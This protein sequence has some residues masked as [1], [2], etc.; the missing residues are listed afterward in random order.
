MYT[1]AVVGQS[2][3]LRPHQVDECLLEAE[4]EAEG[5]IELLEPGSIRFSVDTAEG[6]GSSGSPDGEVGCSRRESVSRA[7]LL[8]Q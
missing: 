5:V 6:S 8:P 3:W 1:Q 2:P 7:V 4:A